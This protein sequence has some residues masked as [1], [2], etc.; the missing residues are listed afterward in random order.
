MLFG[1]D[2]I[3]KAY[4]WRILLDTPV[5][6]GDLGVSGI[7]LRTGGTTTNIATDNTKTSSQS[8]STGHANAIDNNLTTLFTATGMATVWWQYTFA[9]LTTIDSV[10]VIAR[11]DASYTQAPTSIAVF[12]IDPDL[13][14]PILVASKTGLGWTQGANNVLTFNTVMPT[15]AVFRQR[16][17]QFME[18]NPA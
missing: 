18:A 6:G 3:I 9:A 16:S 4:G 14:S 5:S 17:R 2:G 10:K 7:E 15:A 11:N 12:A 13:N 1:T 8:G